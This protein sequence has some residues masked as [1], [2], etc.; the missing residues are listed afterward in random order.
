MFKKGVG[1]IHFKSPLRYPFT[2]ARLLENILDIMKEEGC[3]VPSPAPPCP[4]KKK[5]EEEEE[6]SSSSEEDVRR[7]RRRRRR[8]GR[9]KEEDFTQAVNPLDP[10]QVSRRTGNLGRVDYV[11]EYDYD[12]YLRPD[13]SNPRHRMWFNFTVDNAKA[14][15]FALTFPYSYARLQAFLDVMGGRA[16]R[17]E[18]ARFWRHTLAYS[19][20]S[21]NVYTLYTSIYAYTNTKGAIVPYSEALYLRTGRR[22]VR[23]VLEYYQ[24]LGLVPHAL[25]RA[26]PLH[27]LPSGQGPGSPPLHARAARHAA[28]HHH[29]H[30]QLATART[31]QQ[32]QQQQRGGG[33]RGGARPRHPRW[34]PLS[35]SP[36]SDSPSEGEEQE[37]EEEEEEEEGSTGGGEEGEGAGVPAAG[38]GTSEASALTVTIQ[39]RGAAPPSIPCPPM[40]GARPREAPRE[41]PHEARRPAPRS[42]APPRPRATR[43]PARG[44]PD[45]PPSPPRCPPLR[46]PPAPRRR[47]RRRAP[48]PSHAHARLAFRYYDF[49]RLTRPRRRPRARRA[50]SRSPAAAH[51][52]AKERERAHAAPHQPQPRSAPRPAGWRRGRLQR[53]AHGGGGRGAVRQ[54]AV[55]PPR[56][57]RTIHV[58]HLTIRGGTG[59]PRPP[60]W[61]A[62]PPRRPAPS[63]LPML[64][65][66]LDPRAPPL[67]TPPTHPPAPAPDQAGRAGGEGLGGGAGMEGKEAPAPHQASLTPV[68]TSLGQSASHPITLNHPTM[69]LAW[70]YCISHP[71]FVIPAPQSSASLSVI[72]PSHPS[73]HPSHSPVTPS[74][75]QLNILSPPDTLI[76]THPLQSPLPHITP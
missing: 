35:P 51:A 58:N 63:S 7:R 45:L 27:D 57:L 49:R 72:T 65:R 18:G 47:L 42:P 17:G 8:R 62:A 19:V 52:R 36:P 5:E 15:Q 44:L 2:D 70:V 41:A 46:T 21:T 43:A 68:N 10:R 66:F 54:G 64:R 11:A 23:G 56:G 6:E 32:Q 28:H 22:V 71:K 50:H 9:T 39:R 37:E 55:P 74:H 73:R 53:G 31:Q 76:S 29:H 40:G 33:A 26:L 60:A 1:S 30:H 75:P 14:D 12:L 48:P 13:T 20:D 34:S 69:P 25:P 3:A 16:E 4:T 24:F 67:L 38:E 61:Q 59:A